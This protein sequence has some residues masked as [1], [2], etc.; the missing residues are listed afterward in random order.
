LAVDDVYRADPNG[1]LVMRDMPLVHYVGPFAVD[2]IPGIS[3]TLRASA[4]V[5]GYAA[6]P[7]S[8]AMALHPWGHIYIVTGAANQNDAET[9]ALAACN[10]DTGR[11]GQGGPCYLYA[12]ANLVV[13][14]KRYRQPITAPVLPISLPPPPAPGPK[15]LVVAKIDHTNAGDSLRHW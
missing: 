9:R 12:S 6:A 10:G 15:R 5:Q 7:E 3:P 1:N 14:D 13:L 2:R 11:K 8:K 4:D